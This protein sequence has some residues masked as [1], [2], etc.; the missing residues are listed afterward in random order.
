MNGMP[1]GAGALKNNFPGHFCI[2]FYKSSTH[3]KREMDLSHKLMVY[4]AA[5]RMD[6]LFAKAD[7]YEMAA[8]FIAGIKEQDKRIVQQLSLKKIDWNTVF[9]KVETVKIARLPLLPAEDMADELL[10]SVPIEIEWHIKDE[11]RQLAKSEMLLFR[12]APFDNWRVDSS[13]FIFKNQLT[14]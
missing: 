1:H 8:Y 4:K 7:P 5:G 2:H 12:D 11:G 9:D 10:I 3:S 6:E 14:P 13:D